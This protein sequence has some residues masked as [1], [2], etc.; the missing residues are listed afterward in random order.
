MAVNDL[1]VGCDLYDCVLFS[2][3]NQLN[4]AELLQTC[5][6]REQKARRAQQFGGQ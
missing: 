6:R 2:F 4:G 3:N 1:R 5:E